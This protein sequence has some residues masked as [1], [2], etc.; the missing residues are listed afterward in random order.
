MFVHNQFIHK[1]M[2]MVVVDVSPQLLKPMRNNEQDVFVVNEEQSDCEL[3]QSMMWSMMHRICH[4]LQMC[5]AS[6]V[7]CQMSL[8]S[9]VLGDCDVVHQQKWRVSG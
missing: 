5:D 6:M 1:T 7:L 3:E 4:C 2:M 8:K 9:S